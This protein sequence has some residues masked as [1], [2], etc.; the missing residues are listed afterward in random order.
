MACCTVVKFPRPLLSTM[1]VLE[2]SFSKAFFVALYRPPNVEPK[3][4][5]RENIVDIR[6]S[7]PE[8]CKVIKFRNNESLLQFSWDK[9]KKLF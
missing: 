2:T 4:R 9:K 6:D 8:H 1:M 3:R 5:R 7:I